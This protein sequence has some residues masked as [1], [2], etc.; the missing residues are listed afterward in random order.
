[1][2][3]IKPPG[4]L[5]AATLFVGTQQVTDAMTPATTPAEAVVKAIQYQ[6]GLARLMRGA[7]YMAWG[8]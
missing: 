3:P 1:M 7:V 8:L 2:T 5:A 4:P 6:S